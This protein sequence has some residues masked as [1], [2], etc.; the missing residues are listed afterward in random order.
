MDDQFELVLW[1]ELAGLKD[2]DGIAVDDSFGDSR[3]VTSSQIESHFY[4]IRWLGQKIDWTQD[5]AE[6][7]GYAET[8]VWLVASSIRLGCGRCG[9][10]F[11]FSQLDFV[12]VCIVDDVCHPKLI[13]ENI[14]SPRQIETCVGG[15]TL[16]I[17]RVIVGLGARLVEIARS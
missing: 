14:V 13:R 11:L 9:W 2:F 4:G 12:V 7:I 3:I 10:F 6:W 15:K 5:G 1:I 17:D 8:A 16:P